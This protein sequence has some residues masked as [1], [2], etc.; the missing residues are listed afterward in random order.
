MIY[1]RSGQKVV[2]IRIPQTGGVDIDNCLRLIGFTPQPFLHS[3]PVA[4]HYLT[5]KELQRAIRKADPDKA[6]DM[7]DYFSFAFVRNPY[8][9]IAA[10]WL[11]SSD[12]SVEFKSWV[13]SLPEQFEDDPYAHES[14]L[15]PQVDF[16]SPHINRIGRHENIIGDY[17]SILSDMGIF[18]T[19]MAFPFEPTIDY[20]D[21][22]DDET[23][24]V[25]L[26]MYHMDLSQF[27]YRY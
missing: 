6:M 14:H 4:G 22:Y 12:K 3:Y 19:E 15:R 18:G 25:I 21:L 13:L 1:E 7:E 8:E 24:D 2:F 27:D 20:H 11:S 10:Q 5:Y 26:Q 9:R 16:L 17:L 23:R